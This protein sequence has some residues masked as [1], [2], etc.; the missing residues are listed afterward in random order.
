[1][2]LYASHALI[3]CCWR[4]GR[5]LPFLSRPHIAGYVEDSHLQVTSV[6]T[7]AKLV[8]LARN[9]KAPA[10]AETLNE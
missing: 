7:T 2:A 8:A 1:M 6:V 9:E 5:Q 4:G 10:N 3:P